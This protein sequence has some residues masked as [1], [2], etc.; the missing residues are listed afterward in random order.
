MIGKIFAITYF[1]LM[2]LFL[3]GIAS[4][5][6]S[7]TETFQAIDERIARLIRGSKGEEQ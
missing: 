6:F 3:L 2:G 4:A 1:V 7:D 5:M